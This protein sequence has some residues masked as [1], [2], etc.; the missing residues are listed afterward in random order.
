M[1]I[2]AGTLLPRNGGLSTQVSQRLFDRCEHR[3]DALYI[4]HAKDSADHF[5]RSSDDESSAAARQVSLGAQESL[6]ARR[7]EIPKTPEIENN[8]IIQ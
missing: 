4:K 2:A 6:D 5:R 7:I 3:N 1:W 8:R